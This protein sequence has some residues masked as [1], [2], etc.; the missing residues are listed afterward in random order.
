MVVSVRTFFVVLLDLRLLVLH[1][2]GRDDAL[3]QDAGAEAARGPTG[4]A[5]IEDQLHLIGAADVEILADDFF[6][7]TAAGE[8]AIEDLGQRK[9]RLED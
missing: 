5:S 9:L 3:R 7:E 4:D 6:E 2:Q 1:V 8:G